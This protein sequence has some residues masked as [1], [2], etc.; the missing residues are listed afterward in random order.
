MNREKSQ[1]V[2]QKLAASLRPFTGQKQPVWVILMEKEHKRTW[3]DPLCVR[4][5][6]YNMRAVNT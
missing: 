3:Y 6:V 5:C 4:V 1:D 2:S